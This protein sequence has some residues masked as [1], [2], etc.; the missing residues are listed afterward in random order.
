MQLR[1]NVK[2]KESMVNMTFKEETLMGLNPDSSQTPPKNIGF[3]IS[4]WLLF[5]P[6]PIYY[7]YFLT[8]L[9]QRK[10]KV[11]IIFIDLIYI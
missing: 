9:S 3:L 11:Y 7:R 4:S 5:P 6:L 8:G 1:I 2:K 10:K